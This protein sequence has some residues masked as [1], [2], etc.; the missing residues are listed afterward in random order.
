LYEFTNVSEVCTASI[1]RAMNKA[2]RWISVEVKGSMSDRT[3]A[4]Q[5]S[6]TSVNLY[7]STRRYNPEDSHLH[8]YWIS[9]ELIHIYKCEGTTMFP[10]AKAAIGENIKIRKLF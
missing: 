6:E 7:E 1:I 8:G 9:A 2:A 5:T 4:V 10:F 3:E